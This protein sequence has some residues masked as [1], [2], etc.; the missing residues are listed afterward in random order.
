MGRK[1]RAGEKH[2]FPKMDSFKSVNPKVKDLGYG[3]FSL[4]TQGWF[5]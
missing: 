4:N 1:A 3:G 2:S 5:G